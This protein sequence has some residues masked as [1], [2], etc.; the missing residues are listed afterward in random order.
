M[1]KRLAVSG[2]IPGFPVKNDTSYQKAKEYIEWLADHYDMDECDV[3]RIFT[4]YDSFYWQ[5]KEVERMNITLS[6]LRQCIADLTMNE[7]DRSLLMDLIP[8]TYKPTRILD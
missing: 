2:F 5:T 1:E 7:S 3:K 6:V 4:L 8:A